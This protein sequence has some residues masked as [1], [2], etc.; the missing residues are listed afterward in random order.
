MKN[1]SNKKIKLMVV[2]P[3]FYPDSGGVANYTYNLYKRIAKKGYKV[4]VVTSWD[5]KNIKKEKIGGMKI[6]RLPRQ[7]KIS[8]T[9]ISFK[10]KKQI[11]ELIDCEKPDLINGHMPVPFICDVAISVSGNIPFVTGYH[12][13]GSMKKGKLLPDIMIRTYES[14]FLKKLLKKSKLIITPSEFVTKD[15]MK[16]YSNKTI[17][18]NPGVDI[19]KFKPDYS[20]KPVNRILFVGNLIKSEDYKG[21]GYLLESIKI[22]R[23]NIPDIKLIVVG[24]GDY[25]EHYE[26]LSKELGIEE[27]IEF[28]G[29]LNREEIVKEYQNTNVL[30]LPSLMESFGMVLIEAMACKKPVIGTK[31]GGIPYVIDNNKNG[32][33]VPPKDSKELA[34]VIT[35]IL[36][37]KKLAKKMGESGYNKVKEKFNWEIQAE[38]TINLYK[39]VLR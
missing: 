19:Q 9:P 35:H 27:N 18:V 30:V 33:L 21:L 28:R 15:F 32:L 12:H 14:I 26:N 11:K 31:V 23:K 37:N 7:F 5:G 38:K 1:E 13:G 16:N 3:Y 17:T 6:Y 29:K 10:W 4:I 8:N 25:R 20:L 36:K 24:E 39:E 2:T 22:I 34:R